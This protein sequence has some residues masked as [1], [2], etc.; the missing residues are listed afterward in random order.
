MLHYFQPMINYIHLHPQVGI[1]ITVLVAFAESLPIIGT[2]LPGS[3]TMTAIGTMIGTG[4]LPVTTLAWATLGA[5]IGDTLGF[6]VGYFFAEQIKTIWPFK[7]Y[8]R[9]LKVSEDFFEKHGGKSIIIGR[10]VGPARSTVPM[11][12]GL[13]KMPW[14]RFFVAAVPSAALWALLYMVPGILL[15]ALAVELPP[16]IATEFILVGLGIIVGIWLFFWALQYFFSQLAHMIN[17]MIDKLWAQLS[18]HKPSRPLLRLIAVKN[19]PEDHYQLTLSILMLLSA[20][21]FL[22]IFY[23]VR[24]HTGVATLNQPIF[25][26]FQSLRTPKV[27]HFFVIITMLGATHCMPIISLLM[28]LGMAA[29]RQWRAAS[30]FLLTSVLAYC[31]IGFFKYIYYS[32]RPTG[33]NYVSPHSSFP[34]GHTGMT[35]VILSLIAYFSRKLLKPNLQWLPYVIVTPI[36][37]L[38]AISRLYLGAHWLADIL[39]SFTL[40]L[41]VLF[42]TIML[43]RRNAGRHFKTIN[44]KYWLALCIIA[45]TLPWAIFSY[46]QYH[47]ENNRYQFS[48]PTISTTSSRWWRNATRYTPSYRLNRFGQAIQPFNLQF[49]GNLS[50]LKNRL[51]RHNWSVI[52][53]KYTVKDTL[54]RFTNKQQTYHLP[55]MPWLYHHRLPDLILMKNTHNCNRIIELRL[56]N[57]G[58]DFKSTKKTLWIGTINYQIPPP[59]KISFSKFKYVSLHESGGIKKLVSDL[60]GNK[61][62]QFKMIRIPTKHQPVRVRKLNWDGHIIMILDVK[63]R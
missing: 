37:L 45:I 50:A 36:I 9:W 3:I 35:F 23:A 19:K 11:V 25:S 55:L 53:P 59:K 31:A 56:W 48:W 61:Q 42:F 8:P 20:I 58:I 12:A 40:G 44:K 30:Y 27:Y 14:W 26:L 22:L 51:V 57:S 15:G 62:Y 16:H 1:L 28:T 41:S 52:D 54:Q 18:Q 10:F 49:S 4:V 2:I 43:Y 60:K 6:S 7:K 24:H 46:H 32:P 29:T 17:L 63:P 47:F 5:L 21:V 38:V 13:L 33:F 34:S 39:G